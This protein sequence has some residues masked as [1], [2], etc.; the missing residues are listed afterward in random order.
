MVGAELVD[1]LPVLSVLV[2]LTVGQP[3]VAVTIEADAMRPHKHLVSPGAQNLPG[4]TQ[5]NDGRLRAGKGENGP[6]RVDRHAGGFPP[7]HAIRQLLAPSGH[8]LVNVLRAQ[9]RGKKRESGNY[10]SQDRLSD[11]TSGLETESMHR[12]ASVEIVYS[13][14]SVRATGSAARSW[15]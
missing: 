1:K 6:F 14:S 3:H 13:Y 2:V 4:G 15:L 11:D 5:F 8:R 9:A 10:P 12:D 7:F